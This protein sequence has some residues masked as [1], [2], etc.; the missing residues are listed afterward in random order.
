MKTKT[1]YEL[2]ICYGHN[3]WHDLKRTAETEPRA[4]H[5]AETIARE[6]TKSTKIAVV[7]VTVSRITLQTQKGT[8][9]FLKPKQMHTCKQCGKR[10]KNKNINP[11]SGVC[12]VCEMRSEVDKKQPTL[13]IEQQYWDTGG[14]IQ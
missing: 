5:I 3:K 7:A 1:Y 8:N 2:W 14:Y 9:T 10:R 11:A 4:Q 13:N 12:L 6:H